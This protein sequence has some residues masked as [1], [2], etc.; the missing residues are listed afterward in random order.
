VAICQAPLAARDRALVRL[1]P[2][3]GGAMEIWLACH[4]AMSSVARVRASLDGIGKGIAAYC[5]EGV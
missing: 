1:F 3:I 5:V 2:S 4:P